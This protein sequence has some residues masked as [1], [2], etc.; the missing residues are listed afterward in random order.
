VTVQVL[1]LAAGP[2]ALVSTDVWFLQLPDG[3]MAAYREHAQGGE[4][5]EETTAVQRA[6][7]AYD[8][9][10]DLALSPAE[11]LEFIQRILEEVPCEEP[12]T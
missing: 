7:R 1:P 2:Y 10:R 6:Q 5:V 12:S 3:Y 11:S 9:V 8:E 4:L